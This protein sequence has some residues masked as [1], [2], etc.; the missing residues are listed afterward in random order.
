MLG[1]KALN[2][3]VDSG[4]IYLAFENEKR[5]KDMHSGYVLRMFAISFELLNIQNST[6]L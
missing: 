3:E 5:L 1:L 2:M 6:V 4:N